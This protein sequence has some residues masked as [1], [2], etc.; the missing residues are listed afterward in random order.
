MVASAF[1]RSYATTRPGA[2]SS[3]GACQMS[4][5]RLALRAYAMRS[6]TALGARSSAGP[7]GGAS[8]RQAVRAKLQ[9]AVGHD[10]G[11]DDHELSPRSAERKP[12]VDD[13]SNTV[14]VEST[15]GASVGRESGSRM[16]NPGAG[17]PA[18]V[19]ICGLPVVGASTRAPPLCARWPTTGGSRKY[20][21]N[22]VT[23]QLDEV[24]GA[25][26]YH[27]WIAPALAANTSSLPSPSRS[28]STGSSQLV[29]LD[30]V[31]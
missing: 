12:T 18:A 11:T 21:G 30:S 22:A 23:G 28:A 7:I 5:I 6:A 27:A 31:R 10:C 15:G 14:R 1:R 4:R 20:A 29:E 9:R 3:V 24:G 2:P 26:R 16:S 17:A 8:S 19:R 25:S 13:E